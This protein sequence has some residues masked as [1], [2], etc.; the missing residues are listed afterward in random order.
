MVTTMK[1]MVAMLICDDVQESIEFYKSVLGFSV[2][3]RMDTVG[4]TGWASLN[5]GSV[6]LM[7]ASPGYISEPLKSN[8]RYSQAM[9]YFYPEDVESLH[10]QIRRSGLTASDLTARFYGMTEFEMLDPSGHVLVF[11]QETMKKSTT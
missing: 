8:G 4:K 6:Q 11:G 2:V 5:N 7:L 1:D 9:Y 3:N 10:A